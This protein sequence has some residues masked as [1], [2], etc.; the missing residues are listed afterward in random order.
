MVY[1]VFKDSKQ[2][3]IL[4]CIWAESLSNYHIDLLTENFQNKLDQT[5]IG[6][7]HLTIISA[8]KT[9]GSHSRNFEELCQ[10]NPSVGRFLPR[11][12]N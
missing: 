12:K 4:H 9:E 2:T 1:L 5:D 10:R 11:R 3:Q 6:K 8:E 7:I